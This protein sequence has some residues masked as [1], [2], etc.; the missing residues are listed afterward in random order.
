MQEIVGVGERVTY[1][2]VVVAPDRWRVI[3]GPRQPNTCRGIPPRHVCPRGKSSDVFI[4]IKQ[5]TAGTN[6]SIR[7]VIN[8]VIQ[9][10]TTVGRW[11][12]PRSQT[13][14]HR[15]AAKF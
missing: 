14:H 3:G 8:R 12:D 6:V 13:S 1:P 7:L 11:R 2:R 15:R 10:Q 5:V 9:T 4:A